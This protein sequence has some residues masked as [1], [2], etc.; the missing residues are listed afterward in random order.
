MKY[1]CLI[2]ITILFIICMLFELQMLQ[3]NVYNEKNKYFSFLMKDIKKNYNLYLLKFLFGLSL[4]IISYCV[5]NLAKLPPIASNLT[6]SFFLSKEYNFK[7]SCKYADNFSS[8]FSGGSAQPK[9]MRKANERNKIFRIIQK[10]KKSPSL[11]MTIFC[12]L[13][14]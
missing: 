10:Y 14:E 13:K 9:R 11:R 4:L 6:I 7:S 5:S 1:I 12:K 2:F 8:I 3:Q